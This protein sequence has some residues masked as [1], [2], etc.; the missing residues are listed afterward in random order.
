MREVA[1]RDRIQRFMR[2]LGAEAE[3]PTRVYFTGGATAVLLGWRGSTIDV[4][5]RMEP[6]ADRLFRAIPRI[7]ESL[8]LNIELA[9]P[10]DFI[11]VRDGW[12]DRS[13][14]I[15]LEGHAS[16]HHFDPYAQALSKVER[17]HRQDL[18]DVREM[19]ARGLITPAG[20]WEYFRSIRDRL[21][22]YPAIDPSSF[23]RSMETMFG[24]PPAG[25]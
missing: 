3:S 10:I 23:Q 13:P 14:F 12:Q 25:T 11:P 4:D 19:V 24:A 9:S 7:K 21:Y 16:F 2:A 18:D 8:H 20:A 6:E 1:D 22:R 15:A 17:S 5:I